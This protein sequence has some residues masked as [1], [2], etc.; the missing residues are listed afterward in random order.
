M[1]EFFAREARFLDK[2]QA[3]NGVRA[4]ARES[5]GHVFAVKATID[6]ATINARTVHQ[7]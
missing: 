6:L 3:V 4:S 5:N 2:A 1:T 7:V